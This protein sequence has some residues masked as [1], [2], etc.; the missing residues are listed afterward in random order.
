MVSTSTSCCRTYWVKSTIFCKT[1]IFCSLSWIA[2]EFV[3]SPTKIP[4]PK[5]VAWIVA[6][7][8]SWMYLKGGL[9]SSFSVILGL[10]NNYS[11]HSF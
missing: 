8:M 3:S 6:E 4:S 9:L 1:S 7:M 11:K 2:L 5:P 10:E